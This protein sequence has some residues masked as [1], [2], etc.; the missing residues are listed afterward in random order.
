MG[1]LVLEKEDYAVMAMLDRMHWMVADPRGFDLHTDHNNLISLFDPTYVV[2]DLSQTT[3]RR[4]LRW[5]ARIS[6]YNFT[7]IHIKGQ[8][9]VWADLLSRWSAPAPTIRFLVHILELYSSYAPVFE[10]PTCEEI[11]K[12]QEESEERAFSLFQNTAGGLWKTAKKEILVPDDAA[13]LQLR[14]CVTAQ[15][16]PS[17]HRGPTATLQPL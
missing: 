8:D 1:W 2:M 14:P 5:D 4:V 10:W 7:S 3:V 13:D 9:N 11:A 12:V 16:G 17:G 6:V 15:K